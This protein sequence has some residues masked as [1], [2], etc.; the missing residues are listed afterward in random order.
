MHLIAGPPGLGPPHVSA[1][2]GQLKKALGFAF[3]LAIGIGSVIGAGIMRTTG[4]VVDQVPAM[5]LVLGLWAFGGL[6]VL[7]A[8]NVASELVTAIPRTGGVFVPVR[9]AFGDSMGL[10]AGW[11]NWLSYAAAAAA[12]SI[13]CA[14]FLAVLFPGLAPQ[15]APVAIGFAMAAYALNWLGV[16]EGGIAQTIGSGVKLVFLCGVIAVAFVASPIVAPALASSGSPVA[17][18][19]TTVTLLGIVVAYQLIYGAYAGWESS[20]NFVEED[21][22]ALTNIPRAMG[23]SILAISVVYLL[24]NASLLRAL[25]LEA[26]RQ[27]ELPV[28]VMLSAMLGPGGGSVV[29]VLAIVLAATS[30]NAQVMIA[31]RTLY[32][33]AQQGLFLPFAL[34]VNAGGTPDA[35]MA[36]TG[37]FTV[38]LI[39]SGGFEFVFRLMGALIIFAFV[40]YGAS[41]FALR[42]SQP[43]LHRPFRAIGYPHLPGFL[44][45]LDAGLLVAFIAADPLSGLFMAVLIAICIPIG[46]WLHAGRSRG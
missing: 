9:A 14:N 1:G 36:M 34:R 40:L 45:L 20:I 8:A 7:L 30:L 44:L 38:L 6:H 17:G 27:S 39:F 37:V 32:G 41:L 31:P 42:W 13:V 2:A 12:L 33:L 24:L 23:L 19:D 28:A 35:A 16:R 43:G 46:L 25:D 29:A 21:H 22:N 15:T 4:P 10:L 18:A 3:A 26:I 11:V 5:W